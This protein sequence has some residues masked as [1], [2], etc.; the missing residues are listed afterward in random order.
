MFIAAFI[1]CLHFFPGKESN[2]EEQTTIARRV[3]VEIT[4]LVLQLVQ[5]KEIDKKMDTMYNLANPSKQQ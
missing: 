4:I 2:G 5:T 3:D 1:G